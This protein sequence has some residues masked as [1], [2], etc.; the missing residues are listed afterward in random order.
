MGRMHFRCWQAAEGATVSAICEANA[1]ALS[2]KKGVGG[3][4]EGAG[5]GVDL[6]DIS[7]Y[8]DF[9]K[10]LAEAELDAL[11]IALP[12]HL[13]P[14]TAVKALNNGRHVLCE[15]PMALTPEECDPMIAAAEQS[16]K[17]LM[18]GHCI[19]FWPEYAK[20]KQL[21]D[22]GELGAVVS[23]TFRR[24]GALPGW[25]GWFSDKKQSGGM[26]LDLHIHDTDFVHYLFGMPRAVC[27]AGAQFP[28]GML[29]H[30]MT[31]Y[32]YGDNKVVSAEGSWMAAPSFGF[33]MSFDIVLEKATI[34]LD[35]WQDPSFRV[36]PSEGEVFTPPLAAGD[37][38]S[39]QIEHFARVVNGDE[40]LNVVTPAQSRDSVRIVMAEEQSAATREIVVL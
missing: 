2:Q 40:E 16:G 38:Y 26:A 7:I 35:P 17:T 24:L 11:S 6:T 10:M 29:G 12:T 34:V 9:D 37:G 28:N 13:H 25:S 5:D 23:A 18:I 20:T 1:E 22:G 39:R 27:A 19:R 3:N 32:D 15:K 4:I 31:H 8:Q 14:T 21:I 36:C 33:E 30:I